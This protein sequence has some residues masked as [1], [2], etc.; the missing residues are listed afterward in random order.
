[1]LTRT[2]LIARGKGGKMGG[3]KEG[4]HGMWEREL[5]MYV[6]MTFNWQALYPSNLPDLSFNMYS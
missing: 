6:G 3:V 5:W 2:G 4:E 1:M